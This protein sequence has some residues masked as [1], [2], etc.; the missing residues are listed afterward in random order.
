M[1]ESIHG[2]NATEAGNCMLQ[3]VSGGGQAVLAYAD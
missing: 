1:E 2:H 3:T